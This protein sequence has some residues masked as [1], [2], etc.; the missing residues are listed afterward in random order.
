ME[1]VVRR[2]YSVDEGIVTPALPLEL[3]YPTTDEIVNGAEPIS[4]GIVALD[5]FPT[6]TDP[7]DEASFI[8][9]DVTVIAAASFVGPINTLDPIRRLDNV[10]TPISQYA[11]SSPAEALLIKRMQ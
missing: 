3:M 9:P 6:C 11:V 4:S 2:E 1:L 7:L 8:T 10:S 5:V